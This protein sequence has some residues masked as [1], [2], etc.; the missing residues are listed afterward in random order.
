[1]GWQADTLVGEG[2]SRLHAD[3]L[4]GGLIH[5][6]GGYSQGVAGRITD[7]Y[8]WEG[9]LAKMIIETRSAHRHSYKSP[10]NK[11]GGRFSFNSP[12]LDLAAVVFRLHW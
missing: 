7:K 2:L 6:A 12:Q 10:V 3:T 9:N 1:M 4:V 8:R 11:A 5:M